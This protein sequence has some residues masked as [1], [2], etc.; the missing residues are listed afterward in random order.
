MLSSFDWIRRSRTGTE[1]LA[2]L[3]YL[4][5]EKNL[6]SKEE[7]IGPPFSALAGLCHRCW[8]YPCI[9]RRAS[10][11]K[12]CGTIRR[13][14]AA[15]CEVSPR[16][17]LIW[18]LVNQIPRHF[19]IEKE[20]EKNLRW[21]IYLHDQNRFLR[22]LPRLRIKEWLQDL[23]IRCGPDLTGLLQ[24][25]PTTGAGVDT[26][27]GDVLCRVILHEANFPMDRLRI[28]FY[29][30][31]HQVLKPHLRE[32]EGLLTFE[33]AEFLQFL[34]MAEVFR[35]LLRPEEQKEI[36]ELLAR[37]DES[38]QQF[39]W[40][41]LLGRLDKQAKDML[42]AWGIRHWPWNKIHLLYELID[43]VAFSRPA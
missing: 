8:I 23:V 2:T 42:T 17:I 22:V 32:Q 26:S 40:G 35:A 11:C 4:A 43:Y 1:L 10:Y 14:G 12:T 6:S 5:E 13:I 39:Y 30:H 25:F 16:S 31:P 9:S 37:G 3:R 7:K 38:G 24:I 29:S 34:E 20:R 28:R 15:T 33:V 21:K 41:R 18:G 27:M 36:S 19:L